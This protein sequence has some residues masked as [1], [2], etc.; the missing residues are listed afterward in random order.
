MP[1]FC[2][3]SIF[4]CCFVVTLFRCSSHVPLFRGIPTVLPVFRCS[5]D[6]LC[7]WLYSMPIPCS[8]VSG[9]NVP[10]FIV[11]RIR[12]DFLVRV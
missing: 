6:V 1:S 4:W 7:S 9:F 10:S 12:L 8:G 5:A 2:I 3:G 11:C